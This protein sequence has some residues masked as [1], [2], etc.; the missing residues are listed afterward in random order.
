[1]TFLLLQGPWK[2][3]WLVIRVN[4]T[5]ELRCQICS[6]FPVPRV[7]FQLAK[8][9][10]LLEILIK[11]W[12]SN[13]LCGGTEITAPNPF[14]FLGNSLFHSKKKKK[15]RK[16]SI[17]IHQDISLLPFS[18]KGWTPTTKSLCYLAKSKKIFLSISQHIKHYSVH[19]TLSLT[20]VIFET[21]KFMWI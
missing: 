11:Y 4:L 13:V 9:S 5:C 20:S 2:T 6:L 14:L 7:I 12:D 8:P 18:F 19:K 21:E 17:N 16:V 10:H 1:M 15:S 3:H